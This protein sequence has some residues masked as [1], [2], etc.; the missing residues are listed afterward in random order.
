MYL[1]DLDLYALSFQIYFKM[2]LSTG[3]SNYV[4][5]T[6][7]AQDRKITKTGKMWIGFSNSKKVL[8]FLITP[9]GITEKDFF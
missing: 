6:S 1:L 3:N 8:A 5:S 7:S 4:T 2:S 9:V